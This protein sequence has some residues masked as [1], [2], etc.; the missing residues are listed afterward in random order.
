MVTKKEMNEIMGDIEWEKEHL[1][2]CARYEIM[3]RKCT[4]GRF[5]FWKAIDYIELG[6]PYG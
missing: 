4:I 3:V 6:V 1:F 5:L 2:F